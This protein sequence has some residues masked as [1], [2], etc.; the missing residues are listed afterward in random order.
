MR[1]GS[2]PGK[3]LPLFCDCLF[4]V[5]LEQRLA[6]LGFHSGLVDRDG[7]QFLSFR[8]FIIHQQNDGV[9]LALLNGFQSRQRADTAKF[10]GTA[11]SRS[12]PGAPL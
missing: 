8:R 1:T 4:A 6:S 2:R 10:S 7:I 3:L 11:I 12:H 5:A 9:W